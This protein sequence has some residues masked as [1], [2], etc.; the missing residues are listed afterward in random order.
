MDILKY[1]ESTRTFGSHFWLKYKDLQYDNDLKFIF[2]S[3]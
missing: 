3:P 2:G 1:F